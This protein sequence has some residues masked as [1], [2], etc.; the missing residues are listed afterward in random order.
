MGECTE[1]V[2]TD[3]LRPGDLVLNYDM[4]IRLGKQHAYV[5]NRGGVAW[6]FPGNVENMDEV[7]RPDH[8]TAGLLKADGR[9]TIQGN[10][11]ATW[12]R[13]IENAEGKCNAG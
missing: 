10:E 9:W 4:R 2:S 7:F 13:I 5:G 6:W 8:V 3:K 1:L 12:W 11:I